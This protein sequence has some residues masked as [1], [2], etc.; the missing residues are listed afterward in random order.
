MTTSTNYSH[1]KGQTERSENKPCEK[2]HGIVS[3]FTTWDSKGMKDN[4]AENIAHHDGY[5][6]TDSQI[7][8]SK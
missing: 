4:A 3:D 6:H 7:K 8:G 5:F 1:N 2:P